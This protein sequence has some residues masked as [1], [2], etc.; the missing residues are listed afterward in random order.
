ME[1]QKINRKQFAKLL[2]KRQYRNEMTMQEE[3]LA[4]ENGLL[5]IFGASDD[6][7]EFRGL[8]SE[9]IPAYEGCS[10]FIIKNKIGELSVIEENK[11][12]KYTTNKEVE[13]K[14]PN[15]RIIADFN[16]TFID[17]SWLISSEIENSSFDIFDGNDLFCRAIVIDKETIEKVINPN[18]TEIQKQTTK[19]VFKIAEF[20]T[21]P[22]A[23]KG[24]ESLPSGTYQIQKV[25][26]KS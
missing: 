20:D 4:K 15:I 9:E 19:E 1:T 11:F 17:T 24:I 7:L 18:N 2:D 23:M 21:Y 12:K 25:F 26:V 6:L 3:K 22:D 14:I 5:V 13:I 10:A 8:I 16:P